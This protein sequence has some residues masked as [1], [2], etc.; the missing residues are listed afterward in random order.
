VQPA[1]GYVN[2]LTAINPTTD[3]HINAVGLSLDPRV[4][5]HATQVSR[6]WYIW[7]IGTLYRARGMTHE[8]DRLI[9]VS[10]LAKRIG[11]VTK[12]RYLAGLWESSLIEGL[13]WRALPSDPS[14][15]AK[16]KDAP[17]WLWASQQGNFIYYPRSVIT[18][19][20]TFIRADIDYFNPRDLFGAVT[21]AALTLQGRLLSAMLKNDVYELPLLGIALHHP[22]WDYHGLDLTKVCI[23]ALPLSFEWGELQL[24][25]VTASASDSSKYVRV[26]TAVVRLSGVVDVLDFDDLLKSVPKAEIT[27]I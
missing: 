12:S 13:F 15:S 18:P 26:G 21:H 19:V 11:A 24:L 14:W 4:P 10:G 7:L 25:L 27:L 5:N 6:Y 22:A 9:T 8:R 17:S 16:T 2:A 3:L 20:C 1:N 23:M